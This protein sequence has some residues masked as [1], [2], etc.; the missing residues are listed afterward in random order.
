VGYTSEGQSKWV[1][2]DLVVDCS[3]FEFPLSKSTAP[4]VQSLIKDLDARENHSQRGFIATPGSFEIAPNV[5]V[6]GPLYGGNVD[7]TGVCRWHL[8]T[9]RG[10]AEIAD[11][12]AREIVARLCRSG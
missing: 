3:G 10:I 7:A 12:A 6:V 11:I 8:E 5:M 1:D 2:F 9:T 4:L